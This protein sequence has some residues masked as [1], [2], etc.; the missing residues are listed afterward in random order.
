MTADTMTQTNQVINI[1]NKNSGSRKRTYSE[2]VNCA[3]DGSLKTTSKAYKDRRP[4]NAVSNSGWGDLFKN[5]ETF[6]D[7]HL[8]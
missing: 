1:A 8:C 4:R 5:K 7:M 2:F 6:V 3:D